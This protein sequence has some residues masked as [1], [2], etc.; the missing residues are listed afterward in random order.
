MKSAKIICKNILCSVQNNDRWIQKGE[1]N[2][3][4]FKSHI[5]I[6]PTKWFYLSTCVPYGCR[7]MT[8]KASVAGVWSEMIKFASYTLYMN[9]L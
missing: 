2:D 1:V 9:I 8:E 6:Y 5:Y 3:F 7:T 4:F